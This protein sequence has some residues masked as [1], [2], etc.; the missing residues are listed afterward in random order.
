ML[1]QV[2]SQSA[3][4]AAR[5]MKLAEHA[6]DETGRESWRVRMLVLETRWC[7]LLDKKTGRARSRPFG[8]DGHFA[9]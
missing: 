2:V 9:S 6:M 5:R 1:V 8:S 4:V 3:G 7:R